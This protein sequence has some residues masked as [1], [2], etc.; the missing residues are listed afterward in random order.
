MLQTSNAKGRLVATFV[1]NANLGEA[2]GG[3]ATMQDLIRML[4]CARISCALD[5][6]RAKEMLSEPETAA[7]RPREIFS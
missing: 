6:K 1:D 3:S 2:S 7:L 5:S 4:L